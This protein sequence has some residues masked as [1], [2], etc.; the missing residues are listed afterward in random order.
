MFLDPVAACLSPKSILSLLVDHNDLHRNTAFRKLITK[1]G[2]VSVGNL[3]NSEEEYN[4][5]INSVRITPRA[6]MKLCP[7][8]LAQID[9]GVCKQPAPRSEHLLDKNQKIWNGMSIKGDFKFK[10]KPFFYF[11]L[12]LC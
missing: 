7:A 6:F 5:F 11:S 4:Q 1:D 10:D 8:L 3:H 9:N 2:I 12:D